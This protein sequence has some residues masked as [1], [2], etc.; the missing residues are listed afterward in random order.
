M[1]K[2]KITSSNTMGDSELVI[3]QSGQGKQK[4]GVQ[5]KKNSCSSI[6]QK[7]KENRIQTATGSEAFWSEEFIVKGKELIAREKKMECYLKRASSRKRT[8]RTRRRN[9]YFCSQPWL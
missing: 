4:K 3:E 1:A 6:R 7:E 9:H 8:R 2:N 5:I